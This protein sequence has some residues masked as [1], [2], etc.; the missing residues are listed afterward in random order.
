MKTILNIRGFEFL[1]LAALFLNP[2]S[3]HADTGGDG[4]KYYESIPIQPMVV[5]NRSDEKTAP[6][7][8]APKDGELS[9]FWKYVVA[10]SVM[11]LFLALAIFVQLRAEREK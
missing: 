2:L 11:V 4:A 6:A 10:I 8:S 7:A 3:G 9:D 1:L 5:N